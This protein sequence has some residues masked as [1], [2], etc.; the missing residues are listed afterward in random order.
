MPIRAY[1]IVEVS[2]TCTFELSFDSLLFD[3]LEHLK[4]FDELNEGHGTMVITTEDIAKIEG[5][6][7]E[8]A[9]DYSEEEVLSARRAISRIKA[10]LNPWGYVIYRCY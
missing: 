3:V 6:M 2:T 5:L 7:K 9:K 8:A 1:R 10:E 4:M